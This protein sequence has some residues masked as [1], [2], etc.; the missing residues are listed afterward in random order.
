M[1]SDVNQQQQ[2]YSKTCTPAYNPHLQKSSS[3]S[4]NVQKAYSPRGSHVYGYSEAYDNLSDIAAPTT[5]CVRSIPS[6]QMGK[7]FFST[8]PHQMAQFDRDFSSVARC[9]SAAAANGTTGGKK[10]LS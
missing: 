9:S 8:K 5:E 2:P 4:S 7:R 3:F 1:L 10:L 6:F